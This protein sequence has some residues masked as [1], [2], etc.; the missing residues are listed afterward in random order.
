MIEDIF[1]VVFDTVSKECFTTAR[2]EGVQLNG[3]A[4]RTSGC[5]RL[6]QAMVAVSF[7]ANIERGSIEIARFVEVL[8]AC[9]SVRRLGSAALNLA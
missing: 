8:H 1:G 5:E 7:S 2:G 9:Q 4:V 6:E 3:Q